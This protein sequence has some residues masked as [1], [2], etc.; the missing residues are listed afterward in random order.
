MSAKNEKEWYESDEVNAIYEAIM[1][2]DFLDLRLVSSA[3]K[4]ESLADFVNTLNANLKKA[5]GE[6]A[7][8]RALAEK[9]K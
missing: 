4:D 2:S 1:E 6:I 9:V 5:E 3:M 8:T 7:K